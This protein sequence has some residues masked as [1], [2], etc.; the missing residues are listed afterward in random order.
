MPRDLIDLLIDRRDHE[1]GFRWTRVAEWIEA[2]AARD[3]A[4][5][6]EALARLAAAVERSSARGFYGSRDEL[7]RALNAVLRD[8]DESDDPAVIRTAIGL[9]DTLTRRGLIDEDALFEASGRR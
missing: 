5:A 1:D 7:G 4:S 3:P 9:Q 8:A 2:E 6:A